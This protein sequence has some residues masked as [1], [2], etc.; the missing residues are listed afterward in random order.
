M[1]T[2]LTG[3]E[4]FAT[5]VDNPSARIAAH[6]AAAGAPGHELVTWVLPVSFE[7]AARE[8]G[9]LLSEGRFDLAVLMG[10]ARGESMIRLERVGRCCVGERIA[11]AS[12][13]DL[14]ALVADLAGAGIPT[15]L[16]EDAGSYVCDHTYHAALHT[17]QSAGLATRGLFIHVPPDERTFDGPAPGPTMPLEEQVAAVSR[18]LAWL[19]ATSS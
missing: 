5:V 11:L 18:V 4:P 14:D 19:R 8:V 9:A 16:S 2:L 1:R 7:D 13:L 3:F 15:R 6:F 10:V 17:I 12:D